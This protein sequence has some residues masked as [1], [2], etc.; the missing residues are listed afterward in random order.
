LS[1]GFWLDKEDR[2]LL[3]ERLEEIAAELG[4]EVEAGGDPRIRPTEKRLA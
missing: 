1:S 3:V 2:E 4:S